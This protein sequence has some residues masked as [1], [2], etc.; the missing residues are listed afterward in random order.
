MN[1][2]VTLL[3]KPHNTEECLIHNTNIPILSVILDEV[4]SSKQ[5]NHFKSPT[6]QMTRED[7]QPSF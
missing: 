3:L 2:T 7:K 5:D 6:P 4:K 1:A